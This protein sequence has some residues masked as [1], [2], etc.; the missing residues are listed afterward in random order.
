M[1]AWSGRDKVSQ[2][3]T[4]EEFLR[5]VLVRPTEPAGGGTVDSLS[6]SLF[7]L[8]AAGSKTPRLT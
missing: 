6:P 4:A 3:Q 5:L 8:A 7:R 1:R 2:D